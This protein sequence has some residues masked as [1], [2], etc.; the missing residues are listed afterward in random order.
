MFAICG[1]CTD[2]RLVCRKLGTGSIYGYPFDIEK[3]SSFLTDN[4]ISAKNVKEAHA[5]RAHLC[6]ILYHFM[7]YNHTENCK[8]SN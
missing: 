8:N 3:E 2:G 1:P 5:F 6:Y 4:F 7:S